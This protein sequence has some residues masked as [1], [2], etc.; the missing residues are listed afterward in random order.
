MQMVVVYFLLVSDSDPFFS[1]DLHRLNTRAI[2]ERFG[3]HILA[4]G[5]AM[6]EV[7]SVPD[8][9]LDGDPLRLAPSDAK[10]S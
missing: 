8:S 5:S 1:I 9:I 3:N 7:V 2:A 4:G 6:S 10:D